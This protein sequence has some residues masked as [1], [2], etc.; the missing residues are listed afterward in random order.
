MLLS[1]NTLSLRKNYKQN[2]RSAGQGGAARPP[3]RKDM[4]RF[5]L[6]LGLIFAFASGAEARECSRC[7]GRGKI[8]TRFSVSSYG[9]SNKKVK[10]SHCGEWVF[11]NQTHWDECPSCGGTGESGGSSG[12]DRDAP[13]DVYAIYLTED[14]YADYER[15]AAL[16]MRG[17]KTEARCPDCGGEGTCRL[18]RGSGRSPIQNPTDA[19]LGIVTPCDICAGDGKCS[20]CFGTGTVMVDSDNGKQEAVERLKY[21]SK[22][23]QERQR[24]QTGQGGEASGVADA[25]EEAAPAAAAEAKTESLAAR[26]GLTTTEMVCIVVVG[27]ILIIGIVKKFT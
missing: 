23:V 16:A 13:V 15:A 3:A 21:Y 14:E 5:I 12:A 19:E 7:H 2:T 10:C 8:Q 4:K 18:C 1:E 6:L 25:G 17:T 20:K 26:L 11:A 9:A 22:L 24:E 27:I